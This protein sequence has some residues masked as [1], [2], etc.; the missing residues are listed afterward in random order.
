MSLKVLFACAVTGVGILASCTDKEYVGPGGG[1]AGNKEEA[2]L[3]RFSTTQ[4]V[5]FELQYEVAAGYMSGFDV[6]AENPLKETSDGDFVLR[7]N[8]EVVAAG[9]CESGSFN[10][11]KRIPGYIT[12]L[13]AYSDNLFAPRLMY[14][15]IVNGVAKF[16][17]VN[18]WTTSSDADAPSKRTLADKKIDFYLQPSNASHRPLTVDTTLAI[19]SVLLTA[20]DKA[21][22]ES[23]P[24]TAPYIG[25]ASLEIVEDAEL[26]I[27]PLKTGCSLRNA[28]GY[29]CYNGPKEELS[30]LNVNEID[31][32]EIIVFP[33]AQLQT[34][35]NNAFAQE[36]LHVGDAFQLKY[37]DKENDELVQTFPAGTTIVWILHSRAYDVN[38][39][40]VNE[41]VRELNRFYSVPNWNN[42][43]QDHTIYFTF[44]HADKKYLCFGFEDRSLSSGDKDYNDLIFHVEANPGNAIVPPPTITID[45]NDYFTKTEERK[46]VL[47][48]EDNW[49]SKGDYDLNDVVVLYDSEITYTCKAV[50]TATT[51]VTKLEDTFTLIHA[52][53]SYNN[54]FSYKV[55]INPDFIENGEVWI[56]GASKPIRPDGEGFVVD[57]CENVNDV[58]PPFHEVLEPKVYRIVMNIVSNKVKQAG[59]DQVSAPYNPFIA[60][61]EKAGVEVH[62]PMYPPTGQAALSYFGTE[63]DKSDPSRSIYYVAGTSIQYPFAIHLSGISTFK[64]PVEGEEIDYTYPRYTNWVES[65]FQEDKDWY[66]EE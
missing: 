53:A 47:A 18:L 64:I 5:Q 45:E 52:G 9:I 50:A 40:K 42:A 43:G 49:P 12:E 48:F 27:T 15:E 51:Y 26:W 61:K 46:G 7:P 36:G 55:L 17:E 6:Y 62:L 19:P 57:V 25:E 21:F 38:T 2:S 13:Y 23:K 35:E 34:G 58:I 32:K 14:A 59:F 60:P 22:P 10:M 39:Q 31:E 65:G 3:L 30:A 1:D 29:Y 37:Y 11:L 20:I 41:S 8:L 33:W 66:V 63:S 44:E 16:R 28:L 54:A 56:D 4:D 24:A